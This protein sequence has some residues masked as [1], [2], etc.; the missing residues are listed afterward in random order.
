VTKL[1][2]VLKATNILI[3]KLNKNIKNQIGVN[4]H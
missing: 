2:K 1:V 4:D 3:R